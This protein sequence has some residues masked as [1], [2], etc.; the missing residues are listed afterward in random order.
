MTKQEHINFW[1]TSSEEDWLSAK[2]IAAKNE[3][4]YFHSISRI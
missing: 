1:K 3:R 2:E 4:K